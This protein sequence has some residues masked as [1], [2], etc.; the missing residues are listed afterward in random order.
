MGARPGLSLSVTAS[1]PAGMTSEGLNGN[2]REAIKVDLLGEIRVV[3]EL[4]TGDLV[5]HWNLQ[6]AALL[7]AV[8]TV[9]SG[10]S[11]SLALR[12]PRVCLSAEAWP[13]TP[14]PNTRCW[15]TVSVWGISDPK[16]SRGLYLRRPRY[17][18]NR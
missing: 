15:G 8:G 2:E 18:A 10:R 4:E 6:T 13:R 1:T 16:R 12:N 7:R 17:A 5:A 14:S 9:G 11:L 3:P